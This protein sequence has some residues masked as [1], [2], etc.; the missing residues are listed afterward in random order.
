MAE[1]P[2]IFSTDMV[3]AILEGRKTM[4]RRVI[5]PQPHIPILAHSVA[6]AELSRDLLK[7]CPYGQV[8]DRL[9]VRETWATND[10]FTGISSNDLKELYYEQK[11]VQLF[12]RADCDPWH[13]KHGFTVRW[14]PSIFMPRW[15]SRITLEITELRVERLQEITDRDCEREGLDNPCGYYCD[16]AVG[17]VDH[18]GTINNFAKLWDKLNAKRGYGWDTNPWVWVISF[19]RKM[20]V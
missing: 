2:I 19:K 9:W 17:H 13:T 10:F 12:Y 16:E 14:R 15:A 5:K 4:T 3:K 18:Q 11:G 6:I 20:L 1:H 8:S 7:R